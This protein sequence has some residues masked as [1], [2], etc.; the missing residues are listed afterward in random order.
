MLENCLI[1]SGAG[2][3]KTEYMKNR[4]REVLSSGEVLSEE[5]LGITFMKVAAS[6][7]KER[8]SEFPDLDIRTIHSYCAANLKT[9][10]V[11]VPDQLLKQMVAVM[12]TT[13]ETH[14]TKVKSNDIT[15]KMINTML[16]NW[17]YYWFIKTSSSPNATLADFQSNLTQG[18]IIVFREDNCDNSSMLPEAYM[19]NQ[20]YT[21]LMTRVKHIYAK[22][23]E[24][25]Y[26]T[27]YMTLVY[28]Y[29]TV[30]DEKLKYVLVDEFQDFTYTE[31][32][33][34][35]KV[36]PNAKFLFLCDTYQGI[37]KW[38]R[39]NFI[40]N[41]RHFK[42]DHELV[43]KQFEN[44]YRCSKAV[45]SLA[46]LISNRSDINMNG[47]QG[48]VVYESANNSYEDMLKYINEAQ[49]AGESVAV[50][51]NTNK[52]AMNLTRYLKQK[53]MLVDHKMRNSYSDY[54]L[55][56]NFMAQLGYRLK[57]FD[58]Y[59]LVN[60]ISCNESNDVKTLP[61]LLSFFKLPVSS[62]FLMYGD[63]S[64]L[65]GGQSEEETFVIFDTET[66]GTNTSLDDIIQIAA[67]KLD[68]KFNRIGVFN[69]YIK[70]DRDISSSESVHHITKE[71]LEQN[72]EELGSVLKQFINFIGNSNLVAHNTYFD[73]S[74]LLKKLKLSGI[75]FNENRHWIDTLDIARRII[76]QSEVGNYKLETLA[77]VYQ[78]KTSPNHNAMFDVEATVELFCLLPTV[79]KSH[80]DYKEIAKHPYYSNFDNIM[81]VYQD[82]LSYS[83]YDFIPNLTDFGDTAKDIFLL[84][85]FTEISQFIADGFSN[86]EIYNYYNDREVISTSK[87]SKVTVSTVHQAKGLE[88]DTVIYYQEHNSAITNNANDV[89]DE[90]SVDNVAVSRAIKN[91]IYMKSSRCNKSIIADKISAINDAENSNTE[92]KS[93]S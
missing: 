6:N 28:A 55:S 3:G 15:I 14:Y 83:L 91:F 29:F 36:A 26:I 66:T 45:L 65:V 18:D 60:F 13:K 21:K 90:Q 80:P 20:I 23:I 34:L 47:I 40:G 25:N 89:S 16:E 52:S 51:F 59:A 27:Y 50:L 33:I 77:N 86:S 2:T 70:T 62:E 88:F 35:L 24:F 74:I 87:S 5:L 11:L 8:L 79:F 93:R 54:E 68:S 4:I 38:R 10:S 82:I 58:T 85:F 76:P 75:P 31:Y 1:N 49:S 7:M 81:E 30:K 39:S 19:T 48:K 78:F 41:L 63:K 37:F 84:S 44:N 71:F 72:G 61:N 57:P 9:G 69:H 73:K 67:I 64:F 17:A 46:N 22:L 42:K 53:H 43:V 56:A 12:A 92:I 32:L